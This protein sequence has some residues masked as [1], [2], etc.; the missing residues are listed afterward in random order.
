MTGERRAWLFCRE[1]PIWLNVVLLEPSSAAWSSTTWPSTLGAWILLA[2][3]GVCPP[4]WLLYPP[5][6]T[7]QP[8]A[9]LTGPACRP[10]WVR[11]GCPAPGAG[12]GGGEVGAEAGRTV[13]APGGCNGPHHAARP[14]SW[15]SSRCTKS[16]STSS[17]RDYDVGHIRTRVAAGAGL[18]RHRGLHR[19]VQVTGLPPTITM[20]KNSPASA[21]LRPEE[22][23]THHA[24]PATPTCPLLPATHSA[25]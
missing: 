13:P 7:R 20:P 21:N 25:A 24:H 2:A 12:V 6:D 15:C 16:A 10:V 19:G 5:Q 11:G 14:G 1:L 8:H 9:V 23:P 22:V 3:L 4:S 17:A 18:P